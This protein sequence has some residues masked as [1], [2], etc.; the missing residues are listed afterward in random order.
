MKKN[1][2]SG[3]IALIIVSSFAFSA[4]ILIEAE[5]FDDH[6]GWVLDQQFMDQMGSPYL[7]AHG[8]G[9]PVTDANTIATFPATGTYKVWV[10]TRD[11]TG[12]WKEPHF[13]DTS[14]PK[15]SAGTAPG[16]F[17]VI[18]NSVTLT[19]AT[20]FGA[21]SADWQW[22]DGGTVTI[23]NTQ[24]DLT[25]HDLTGFE[26]RCDAI[27]FTT[28]TG[29][30]P[31]NTDPAMTAWRRPLL[32]TD[33]LIEAGNYDL[34]VVGGGMAG[35]SAAVSAARQG[36]SVALIQDRPVLGGNNSSEVR[37]HLGGNTNYAPYPKIGNITN[38]IGTSGGGNASTAANYKDNDK[39]N[40]V[41]NEPNIALYLNHRGNEVEINGSII[42]AVIAENTKT[43]Q[44]V[45]FTAD[46][47][48][49]C[50]GDGCIG[51]L[52]GA[53]WEMTLT[54]TGGGANHMGR[55]NLW[56]FLNTGQAQTFPSCPW[57]Y[58]LESGD[59]PAQT[60]S[61]WFWESGF[62]HDPI[63]K[64]EYIRDCNFRASYGAWDAMKNKIGGYSNNLPE[65]QAYVSGK[66][67][68][69]RLMGDI[70]LDDDDFFDNVVDEDGC[71]PTSW[72]RDLHWPHSSYQSG[73]EGDQFISTY[74]SPGYSA[75]YWI[76]YRCLYS[77]NIDNLF[78]AGRNISVTHY[79]LG[80]VRVMRTTSMM[81]EIVGMAA[82]V[83][84]EQA[85]LPRGVYTDHLPELQ[86]KMG[87]LESVP[88]AA[89][90]NL[91]AAMGESI[92]LDWDDNTDDDL[93]GYRVYRSTT[94]GSGYVQIASNVPF[95]NY[96]D[97]GINTG[98]TYYYVVAAFDDSYNESEYSNEVS[99]RRTSW[100]DRIGPNYG[101]VAAVEVESYHDEFTYPKE[102]LNDGV[103]D[104]TNNSGRWLSSG[105]VLSD[106]VT[107]T[108]PV[109]L[110]LSICRLYSGWNVTNDPIEDFVLQYYTGGTWQDVPQ[111]QTVGNTSIKWTRRFTAVQSDQFRLKVTKTPGNISRIWEIEFYH[112]QMDLNDNGSVDLA[113]LVMFA[114]QWL[115]TGPGLSADFDASQN[116]RVDMED[117]G[118]LSEFWGW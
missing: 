7:L 12:W 34:V 8:L 33:T 89:P 113:D 52:A 75:P 57:A 82:A 74:S 66:R 35:C 101:R 6:G 19:P 86:L 38:E 63:D 29:F 91:T 90:T 60:V 98:I 73:F 58:D 70:I 111:T 53:D 56:R 110:Y 36:L 22:Q 77:R 108:W 3:C 24:V 115:N 100:L 18:V 21:G 55:S 25:L 48:A 16:R 71:V 109:P 118:L 72:G 50:T 69:R 117:W 42:G 62:F 26:G 83:C 14:S 106:Y 37:V 97:N 49:D 80:P 17:E 47:F 13:T 64:S 99:A 114:G 28:D 81:G 116:D 94:S 67:E 9:S 95:S 10:R 107:Y 43:G 92:S 54:S 105:S 93:E 88:P 65:W 85:V 44:R 87:K 68:S 39:L 20:T 96:T 61:A 5:N 23:T 59:F 104:I 78:M 27:F 11:W 103:A 30:I 15:Y 76:P 40:V 79:G 102:N 4:E 46:L 45:R 51:Y 31:P 32:G 84:K 41:L 1:I 2:L 112:P